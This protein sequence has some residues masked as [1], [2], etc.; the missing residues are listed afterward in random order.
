MLKKIAGKASI[1]R[2]FKRGFPSGL[3]LCLILL[4][5][6]ACTPENFSP[7]FG[8]PYEIIV[9]DIPGAP[10]KPP[11]L[12]GDWLFIMV[13]YSGGCQ[14]HEFSVETVVRRDT[15]HIWVKHANGGDSC[16]AYIKD[17]LNLELPNGVLSTR[18]IAMH[19]PAGDPPHLLKWR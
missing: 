16:E 17:D 8:D 6:T 13:A 18:V 4:V 15:A 7:D 10:D 1:Q 3:A 11:I 19:D 12:I 5:P 9:S 14:D 2:V